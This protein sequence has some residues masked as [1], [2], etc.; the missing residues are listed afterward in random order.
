MQTA[1]SGEAYTE[2]PAFALFLPSEPALKKKLL[3]SYFDQ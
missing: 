3:G 1:L 2:L